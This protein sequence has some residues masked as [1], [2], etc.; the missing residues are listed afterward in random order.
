MHKKVVLRLAVILILTVAFVAQAALQETS[1]MPL[2]YRQ[3]PSATL[4]ATVTLTPTATQSPG[5]TKTPTPTKTPN[6]PCLSGKT[7][8]V[9]ITDLDFAPDNGPLNEF[10]TLKNLGSS[11]VS[12]EDWRISSET[13][14]KYDITVD[15]SLGA[16]ATVKIWT[17]SG[18]NDSDEIFMDLTE[19]FWKNSGDCA[20][21][22]DD[23]GDPVDAICPLDE[24]GLFYVPAP[25]QYP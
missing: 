2:V 1:Y 10:L 7:S 25:D 4:T 21:V 24:D 8:G 11:S 5:P 6:T 13:G 18:D 22:K 16:S 19:E 17:K 15:F 20:Y 23:E 9:C 12:L 14:H 3:I